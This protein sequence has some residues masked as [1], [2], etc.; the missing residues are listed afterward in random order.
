MFFLENVLKYF[1]P[2]ETFIPD[3]TMPRIQPPE[4]MPR[5]V[6]IED[7]NRNVKEKKEIPK[8]ESIEK[9]QK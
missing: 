4:K 3:K 8:I 6:T 7:F 1:R 5:L 9:E 2:F